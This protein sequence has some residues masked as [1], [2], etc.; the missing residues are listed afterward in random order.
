MFSEKN[1]PGPKKHGNEE[2]DP[3]PMFESKVTAGAPEVSTLC[4]TDPY[5]I[6][7]RVS[8]VGLVLSNAELSRQFV[9]KTAADTR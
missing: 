1:R 5:A 4:Q 3:L 9:T 7:G 2:T 6:D 8:V